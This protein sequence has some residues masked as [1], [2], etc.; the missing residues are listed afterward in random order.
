MAT[1]TPSSYG[2][3]PSE[4]FK[5]INRLSGSSL[6]VKCFIAFIDH[7]LLS[8]VNLLV[9]I[10]LIKN[11]SKMEYGYYSIALSISFFL[12]SIQ[13]AVVT[14]PLTVLLV[15][16]KGEDRHNYVTS[17][18]WGQF[19]FLLPAIVIGLGVIGLIYFSG[20]DI[21]KASIAG[22]L[23]LASTGILL[24]EFLRA[25]HYAEEAPHDVLKLDLYYITIYLGLIAITLL[26]FK[27]SVAAI[28]IFIG[29]S[30][31]LVYIINKRRLPLI[32]NWNL[33]KESY[34]ENW[35]FGRWSLLG[36]ITIHI[37]KYSYLYLLGALMGSIAVADVSASR[38]LLI[39]LLLVQTSWGKVTRPH[40]AK[41]RENGRLKRYFLE[42]VVA[43][44]T[45]GLAIILYVYAILSF[46]GYLENLL[47]TDNYEK[48]FDYVIFWGVI[49][50]ITFIRMNAGFGLQVI[51]KFNSLAK[52][53][54]VTMI[55]TLCS[56]FF[57]IISYGIEGALAAILL[58]EFI[59]AFSLWWVL[60]AHIFNNTL[61]KHIIKVLQMNWLK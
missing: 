54:V 35:K 11:V 24:R 61:Y 40:G 37:Q 50:A 9:P 19:I 60:G 7:A 2:Y 53:T 21:V 42:L 4:I 10:I 45:G 14:T 56:A 55:I 13:N 12:I 33:I 5:V 57:F 52:L 28:F 32:F 6:I 26:F 20:L 18:C 46:S 1:T 38:L 47:Y 29:L 15:N 43:S 25:Y 3:F 39:P 41:L 17:L 49:F 48:A 8:V 31:G 22:A 58:G 44:S 51:K 23:C 36:V 34:S 16:K 27:L 30:A 59:L